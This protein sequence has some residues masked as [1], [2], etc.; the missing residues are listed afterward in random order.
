[1]RQIKLTLDGHIKR[2][3]YSQKEFAELSGL[4]TATISQLVNNKYDRIQLAHLLTVM[5]TLKITDFNEILTI[6][7][8]PE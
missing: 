3:G 7:E 2:L 1:M 6:E 4:R 8:P 5:E